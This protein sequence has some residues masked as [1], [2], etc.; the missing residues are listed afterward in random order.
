MMQ[1]LDIALVAAA[2]GIG[3]ALYV[4]GRVLAYVRS[5]EAR[6]M[7]RD[8]DRLRRLS[9]EHKPGPSKRA[10]E[11]KLIRARMTQLQA[12]IAAGRVSPLGPRYQR[13]PR[14]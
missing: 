9:R 7:Q 12:D 11:R 3:F 14:S 2:V 10:E 5:A 6:R 8:M 4:A 13:E 1:D